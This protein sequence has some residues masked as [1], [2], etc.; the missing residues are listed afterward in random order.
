LQIGHF[1]GGNA[2]AIN[3]QFEPIGCF[4]DFLEG[5]ADLGDE[6]GLLLDASR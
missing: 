2:A 4:F 3:Q 6:F 5:I 1:G